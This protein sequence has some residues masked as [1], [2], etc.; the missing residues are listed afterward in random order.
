MK[1]PAVSENTSSPMSSPQDREFIDRINLW[2]EYDHADLSQITFVP[3]G[4]ASTEVPQFFR[5]CGAQAALEA[6][7]SEYQYTSCWGTDSFRKSIADNFSHLA[8]YS[9]VNPLTQI[10]VGSGANN[11]TRH[12][13][14]KY[15]HSDTD[16]ILFFEPYYPW[17]F[18]GLK[19]RG[20]AVFSPMF[21]NDKTKELELDFED[22]KKKITPNTKVVMLCNP[23]NPASRVF[24]KEE[25]SKLTDILNEYPN[26]II[27]EDSAYSVYVNKGIELTY[28]HELS[29]NKSKTF[30][31]FS[32][33]KIF[34]TTGMRIGWSFGPEEYTKNL[35]TEEFNTFP[36]S[37][38]EQKIMEKALEVALQPY[39]G[40]P[41]FWDY[42]KSDVAD[43]ASYIMTE[44]TKLGIE[45]LPFQGSYYFLMFVDALVPFVEEKY[46]YTLCKGNM[47][48]EY[49]DRAVARK[50]LLEE[51]IGLLPCSALY[52]SDNKNDC[53]LRIPVNRDD[54]S[55]RLV[56]QSF[57]KIMGKK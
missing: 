37:C 2:S 52:K 44:L 1:N 28:F 21:Y 42:V 34:N 6:T 43:R 38:L 33:G 41:T 57:C 27:V 26:I 22:F 32:G 4:S 19:R 18:T 20:Q 15:I 24:S 39:Q 17:H 56:V 25:Y 48:Q 5:D 16:E 50:F 31:V 14:E 9:S 3:W 23:H 53:F 10:H 11:V 49:R 47:R 29:N 8:H 35:T 36:P 40:F 55:L 45:C 46:Y 7:I 54:E 51:G 30:T 13:L 12:I